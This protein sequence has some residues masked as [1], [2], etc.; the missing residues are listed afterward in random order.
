VR[1]GQVERDFSHGLASTA[2]TA[3][4]LSVVLGPSYTRKQSYISAR[5][6]PAGFIRDAASAAAGAVG[7]L[8]PAYLSQG[9]K[10]G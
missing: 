9:L 7:C 5:S 8:G 10:V 4:P 2:G 3:L 1:N 6:S